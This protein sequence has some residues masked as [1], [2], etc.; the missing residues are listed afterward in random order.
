MRGVL[1]SLHIRDLVEIS[2]IPFAPLGR[3]VDDSLMGFLRNNCRKIVGFSPQPAIISKFRGSR[4]RRHS[5]HRLFVASF[6]S[7]FPLRFSGCDGGPH[8]RQLSRP[9]CRPEQPQLV[10]EPPTDAQSRQRAAIS[11]PLAQCTHQHAG[12]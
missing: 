7:C 11:V 5:P 12:Y 1:F 4:R 2:A 8:P 9:Q 3:A 10:H 6:L